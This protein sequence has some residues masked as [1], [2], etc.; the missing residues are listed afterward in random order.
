MLVIKGRD[1]LVRLG[2]RELT[3]CWSFAGWGLAV[4]LGDKELTLC[5]CFAGQ[6]LVVELGDRVNSAGVLQGRV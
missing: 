6:G 2:D 5:W 3:L 1:V 4:E